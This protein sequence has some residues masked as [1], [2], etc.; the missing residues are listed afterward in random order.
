MRSYF[1]EKVAAPLYKGENMAVE[2]RQAEHVAPLIRK[3]GTNFADK[4]R[5][6]GL[7]SSLADS[8]DGV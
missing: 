6:L 8:G 4:G 7:Y 2:I 5:S 3:F 1:E